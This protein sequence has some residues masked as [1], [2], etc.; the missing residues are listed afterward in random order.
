MLVMPWISLNRFEMFWSDSL[1]HFVAWNCYHLLRASIFSM[2]ISKDCS[3]QHHILSI[4]ITQPSTVGFVPLPR[5]QSPSGR[6][7]IATG[8]AWR[9]GRA[10]WSPK[11]WAPASG[12]VSDCEERHPKLQYE[13]W[14][15]WPCNMEPNMGTKCGTCIKLVLFASMWNLYPFATPLRV[16]DAEVASS[17][18]RVC[19][20][21]ADQFSA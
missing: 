10:S 18:L 11:R 21:L 4:P 13:T 9:R 12:S 19:L 1:N 2:E 20:V 16:T 3:E 7:G 8:E 5:R 6:C 15:N 17:R 14:R